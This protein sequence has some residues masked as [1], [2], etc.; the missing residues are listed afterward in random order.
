MLSLTLLWC[1]F[2]L[3]EY[4]NRIFILHYSCA[5]ASWCI[6][7]FKLPSYIFI[8]YNKPKYVLLYSAL[9][10]T[11]GHHIAVKSQSKAKVK[12]FTCNAV[13]FSV[14]L[15]ELKH[16]IRLF[17][18]RCLLN[19]NTYKEV[20]FF[21]CVFCVAVTFRTENS[22]QTVNYRLK[23]LHWRMYILVKKCIT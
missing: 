18:Q 2:V 20:S 9:C 22:P 13:L 5:L 10:A 12:A 21:L 4:I 7:L 19:L 1:I 8:Y 15:L 23:I 6:Q 11:S 3:L 17:L 14:F 16:W